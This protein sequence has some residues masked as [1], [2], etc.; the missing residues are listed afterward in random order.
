M[1]WD[2]RLLHLDLGVI[3]LTGLEDANET[4]KAGPS[5]VSQKRKRDGDGDSVEARSLKASQSQEQRLDTCKRGSDK[6][7]P[8]KAPQKR[9]KTHNSRSISRFLDVSVLDGEDEEDDEDEE[10]YGGDDVPMVGHSQLLSSGQASFASWVDNIC[11]RYESGRSGDPSNDTP[12]PSA[13]AL[14]I[15]DATVRVYKVDIMTSMHRNIYLR[16]KSKPLCRQCSSLYP[17]S[18]RVEIIQGHARVS[19]V[20]LCR[21]CESE[22]H[23]YVGATKSSLNYTANHSSSTRRSHI[24]VFTP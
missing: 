15:P 2:T 19:P 1:Y 24:V 10:D 4:A 3:D 5:K 20:S 22:S 16:F 6:D 11:C 12:H 7:G 9:R 14:S 17:R 23:Q 18:T 8:S 13:F 21:S